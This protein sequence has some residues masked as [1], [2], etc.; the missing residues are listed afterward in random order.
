MVTEKE[1]HSPNTLK[2][3]GH[4]LLHIQPNGRVI[5]SRHEIK[6][7]EFPHPFFIV[8]WIFLIREYQKISHP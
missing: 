3:G 5:I 4:R 2:S 1:G 8:L 6:K 7:G